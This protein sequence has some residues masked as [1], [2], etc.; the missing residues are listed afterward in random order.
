MP[1]PPI[2]ALYS[3]SMS[4]STDLNPFMYWIAR[5]ENPPVSLLII[6]R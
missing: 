2:V 3:I 1:Y 5:L 6:T 4:P